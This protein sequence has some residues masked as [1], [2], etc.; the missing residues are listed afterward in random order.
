M[1]RAGICAEDSR[2]SPSRSVAKLTTQLTKGDV[3]TLTGTGGFPSST[4]APNQA[5]PHP[6]G[7]IRLASDN[8]A[9][10][11]DRNVTWQSD[12]CRARAHR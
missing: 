3:I 1:C 6:P 10:I 12:G 11:C 2:N 9:V 8:L 7:L 4:P 5:R